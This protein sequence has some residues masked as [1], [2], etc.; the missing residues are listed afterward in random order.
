MFIEKG[1][2]EN[3]LGIRLASRILIKHESVNFLDEK[4]VLQ[5]IFDIHISMLGK[6]SAKKDCYKFVIKLLKSCYKLLHF[7]KSNLSKFKK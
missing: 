3:L 2:E 6:Y 4:D 1:D 5:S 7:V